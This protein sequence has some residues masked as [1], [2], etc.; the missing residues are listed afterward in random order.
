LAVSFVNFF[1][2]TAFFKLLHTNKIYS[3]FL[4][5]FSKLSHRSN[6]KA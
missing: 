1:I 2:H 3:H 6:S 5:A 4:E